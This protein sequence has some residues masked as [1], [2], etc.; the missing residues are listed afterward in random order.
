MRW[1]ATG[2]I[3]IG[4]EISWPSTVVAVLQSVT[5]T[6]ILGRRNQRPKADTF[7]CSVLSSFAPPA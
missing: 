7:S 2:A 1:N 3:T 6:R 5:S 4:R